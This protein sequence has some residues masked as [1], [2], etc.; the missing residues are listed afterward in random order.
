MVLFFTFRRYIFFYDFKT[1]YNITL[2][3]QVNI[4][5][6]YVIEKKIKK[7]NVLQYIIPYAYF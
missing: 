2:I 6:D 5:N 3:G 1:L 4:L 7:T